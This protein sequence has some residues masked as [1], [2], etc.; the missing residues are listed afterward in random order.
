[1]LT[2]PSDEPDEEGLLLKASAAMVRAAIGFAIVPQGL[3]SLIMAL[4]CP[5][6]D[7]EHGLVNVARQV[8]DLCHRHLPECSHFSVADLQRAILV[9]ECNCFPGGKL[10]STIC[11]INHSCQPNAV[12]LSSPRKAWVKALRPIRAGEEITL[13]YL[14]DEQLLPTLLRRRLLWRS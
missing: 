13:S 3:R 5:D 11:R 8:A 4:C 12:F 1:M 14:G 9:M 2:C 10:F 6:L 7:M